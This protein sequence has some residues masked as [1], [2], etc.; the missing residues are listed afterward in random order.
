MAAV[1]HI[2]ERPR[3]TNEPADASQKFPNVC[4]GG[5]EQASREGS[6][7]RKMMQANILTSIR[8][9]QIPYEYEKKV[10]RREDI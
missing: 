7:F 5:G 10:N 2:L 6:S 8:Q 9:K 3:Y 4:P 1:T